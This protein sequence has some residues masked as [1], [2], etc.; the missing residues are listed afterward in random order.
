MPADLGDAAFGHL[1]A[2]AV[3]V[4]A[5]GRPNWLWD[6]VAPVGSPLPYAAM[7]DV[8]AQAGYESQD[9]DGSIPCE[10]EISFQVSAFAATKPRARSLGRLVA[11]ALNDAPL[12]FDAGTLRYLRRGATHVEQCDVKGPNN[13]NIYQCV[14]QFD[15]VVDRT[16]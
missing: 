9:A 11:A 8:S 6:D 1:V 13:V 7:A 14:V 5:F 2:D 4:A 16:L 15:A 10:D 12:A 3:C